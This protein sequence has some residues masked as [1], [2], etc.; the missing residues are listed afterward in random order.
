MART[1]QLTRYA[2]SIRDH[3][4]NYLPLPV[5]SAVLVHSEKS[6]SLP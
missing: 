5:I 2:P 6:K 4:V 1:I 3:D